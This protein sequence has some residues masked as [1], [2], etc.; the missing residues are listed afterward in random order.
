MTTCNKKCLGVALLGVFI[1]KETFAFNI[2]FS[3][4]YHQRGDSHLPIHD[5]DEADL[6][7]SNCSTLPCI[8]T[9]YL[10]RG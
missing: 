2:C 6:Y 5:S 3:K 4:L 1:H 10:I 8:C 7:Q 9:L